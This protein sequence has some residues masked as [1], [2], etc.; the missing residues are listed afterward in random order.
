VGGLAGS[1][2]TEELFLLPRDWM[3][4][5]QGLVG[6]ASEQRGELN[7]ASTV[8]SGWMASAR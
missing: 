4:L 5:G 2:N 1:E 3:R 6:A 7:V 8:S